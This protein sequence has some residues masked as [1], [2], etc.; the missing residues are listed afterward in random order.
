MSIM[1][2]TALS[3]EEAIKIGFPLDLGPA[4]TVTASIIEAENYRLLM[5]KVQAHANSALNAYIFEFKAN[6]K[7]NTFY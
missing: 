1:M 4:N 7:A 6:L 2:E 3:A 5:A